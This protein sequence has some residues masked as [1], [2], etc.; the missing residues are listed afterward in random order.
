MLRLAIPLL[1][2]IIPVLAG[3]GKSRAFDYLL[4]DQTP[5]MYGFIPDAAIDDLMCWVKGSNQGRQMLLIYG[6]DSSEH[7]DPPFMSTLKL[8]TKKTDHH[9]GYTKGF[10]VSS[11]DGFYYRGREWSNGTHFSAGN[12]KSALKLTLMQKEPLWQEWVDLTRVEELSPDDKLVHENSTYVDRKHGMK[13]TGGFVDEESRYVFYFIK[14]NGRGQWG[15][16]LR[17]ET[18][19]FLLTSPVDDF[20]GTFYK[21]VVGQKRYVIMLGE[22]TEGREKSLKM[23]VP[24]KSEIL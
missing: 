24:Q 15:H 17:M 7:A 10:I 18:D 4:C 11:N 16:S 14:K 20:K 12:K 6:L 19:G 2:L 9:T 13:V 5:E 21:V 22:F 23:L 8:K 3:F 1:P